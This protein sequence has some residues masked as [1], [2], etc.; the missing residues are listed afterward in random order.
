MPRETKRFAMFWSTRLASINNSSKTASV[1]KPSFIKFSLS[2]WLGID[3]T[4]LVE[5]N[6]REYQREFMQNAFALFRVNIRI[7]SLAFYYTKFI[8]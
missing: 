7:I 6:K 1:V 8:F 3:N 2:F 5:A 4:L